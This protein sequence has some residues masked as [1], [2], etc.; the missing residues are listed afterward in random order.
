MKINWRTLIRI[1]TLGLVVAADRSGKVRRVKGKIDNWLEVIR[2]VEE[3]SREQDGK[4]LPYEDV[5]K[6]F[7]LDETEAQELISHIRQLHRA[8]V[9]AGVPVAGEQ[10]A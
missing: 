10:T 3:M 7:A 8:V 5:R 1:L 6:Q 4:P 9:I 2:A